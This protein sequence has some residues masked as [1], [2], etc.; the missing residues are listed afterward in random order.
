M[1]A[2][3]PDPPVGRRPILELE[4]LGRSPGRRELVRL[5][6]V[7]MRIDPDFPVLGPDG[8]VDVWRKPLVHPAVAAAVLHAMGWPCRWRA[9]PDYEELHEEAYAAD[10]RGHLLDIDLVERDALDALPWELSDPERLCTVRPQDV[11]FLRGWSRSIDALLPP[12]G[13]VATRGRRC[14]GRRRAVP[15]VREAAKA[16]RRGSR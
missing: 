11:C 15:S 10:W 12:A 6:L 2:T 7:L 16:R 8:V 14:F 4:W 1:I 9:V 3:R 5:N 13:P